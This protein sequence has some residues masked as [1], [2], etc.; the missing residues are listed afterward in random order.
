MQTVRGGTGGKGIRSLLLVALGVTLLLGGC[1][2]KLKEAKPIIPNKDY[3]KA[4][5]GNAA[6][7]YIGNDACLKACHV[8]DKLKNDF[9]A[10]TMGAQLKISSSGMTIVDCES[11]HGPGSSTLDDLK[12]EGL[13]PK[14]P[15]APISEE[16]KVKIR[17][18]MKKN[19]LNF[20]ELPGPVRSQICLKCHTANADFN[21]HN[22]NASAHALNN[23]SCSDCHPIHSGASLIQSPEH[24]NAA[25]TTKCH[26]DVKAEFMLPSRHPIKENQMYCTACHEQHG[27]TNPKLLR[28]MTV[29][30]TCSRCHTE[31]AGPYLWEHGD[32]MEDCGNCHSKHGSVNENLLKQKSPFL[33]RQC[34]SLHGAKETLASTGAAY[35]VG[36]FTRCTDCHSQV[37][38]TDRPYTSNDG[39]RWMQ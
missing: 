38:G 14:D 22:W 17:E 4:L 36:R 18:I 6:A 31:K 2:A 8:H 16:T 20:D 26:Q 39:K 33:C 1:L 15:N 11:C 30:E 9:D 37:H 13:M 5:L 35:R 19:F 24:I 25:C 27:T 34:H 29:K 3:E 7:D 21:L 12:T 23:V 10:S 32:V 28:G